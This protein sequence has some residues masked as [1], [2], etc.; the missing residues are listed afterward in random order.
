MSEQSVLIA[1]CGTEKITRAQLT[2]VLPP[3]GT[4]THKPIAHIAL[5]NALIDGLG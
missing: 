2:E 5:I 1:H 4:A 3:E